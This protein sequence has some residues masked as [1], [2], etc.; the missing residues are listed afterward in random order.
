MD[1]DG[2][3]IR[4]GCFGSTLDLGI[5]LGVAATYQEKILL[6]PREK[7]FAVGDFSFLPGNLHRYNALISTKEKTG[8]T[9]V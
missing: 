8:W 1:S 9:W 3:V 5:D 7:G 2:A 6:G 4:H